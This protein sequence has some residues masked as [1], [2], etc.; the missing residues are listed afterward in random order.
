MPGVLPVLN[1]EVV[2]LAMRLAL[3][4]GSEIQPRSYFARKN[5]FYPD[6]PKGY[7]ISMFEY[8]II[9]GGGLT[10]DT[11][12]GEKF[13]R[14]NRI[15]LEEDAGKLVH[16]EGSS[17]SYFDVNRC[18]V[19]LVEIVT[20]PDFENTDEI[21]QFL[22]K[23]K[24]ILIFSGVSNGNMEEG[25][26]RVDANTSIRPESQTE[27][28][29]RTEIKNLNSFANV[30]S[31]VDQ[32]IERQIDIVESGGRIVLETLLYDSVKEKLLSMRSKEESH[33]YRYFPEPDL[34]PLVIG[35]DMIEDVRRE[36]PELRSEIRERFETTYGLPAYDS[37]IL[38]GTSAVAKY[39]EETVEAGANPKK[40]SNWIMGDVLRI[41]NETRIDPAEFKVRPAMLA[42]LIKLVEDGSI[43]GSVAK[44][45]FD[46]MAETGKAP[47]NIVKEKGLS[48]ISDRGELEKI[49]AEIVEAHPDEAA[50]YKSG[51]K[52]LLSFF[53]GQVMKIT[54]GKANPQ[55]VSAIFQELLS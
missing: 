9:K 30:V 36:L 32:E 27:L 19:P 17:E 7:Q 29:T 23:L 14:L 35:D 15:H 43:S 55:E 12:N 18:G 49:A 6:L 20:E 38:T 24:E 34:V 47:G 31:A 53:V 42:A 4:T 48:Q 26:I 51:K 28:G 21:S 40:A 50:K 5:Y 2:K 3:R 25:N 52:Q 44:T 8:P 39:F 16:E 22:T 13:I 54:R 41:L 45:V 11:P 37:E 10:V 33:D 1:E 46:E